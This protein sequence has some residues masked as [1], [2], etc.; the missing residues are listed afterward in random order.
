MVFNESESTGKVSDLAYSLSAAS[1]KVKLRIF[2]SFVFFLVLLLDKRV[3]EVGL[4]SVTQT[5]W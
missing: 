5:F 4:G 2:Y 3:V 1:S